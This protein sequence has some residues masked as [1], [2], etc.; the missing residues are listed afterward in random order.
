M[1]FSSNIPIYKQI[2][3]YFLQQILLEEWAEGE[4]VPSVREIAVQ[5]EVNPNTALRAF[6]E[7]Q[8]QGILKNERGVGYFVNEGALKEVKAIKRKVFMEQ[9]L[10]A[11][12]RDMEQLDITMDDLVAMFKKTS[13]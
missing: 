9:K 3:D 13:I 4:R 12:F 6:Q 5:V 10:P 7:L 2:E 8:T 11:L 1:D